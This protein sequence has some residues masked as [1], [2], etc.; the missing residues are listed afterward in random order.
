MHIYLSMICVYAFMCIFLSVYLSICSAPKFFFVHLLKDFVPLIKTPILTKILSRLKFFR[1]KENDYLPKNSNIIIPISVNPMS[2]IFQ[3][4]NSLN[5]EKAKFE[6]RFTPS[7]FNE[8]W[9]RKFQFLAKL[10]SFLKKSFLLSKIVYPH[11]LE[12]RYTCAEQ[13]KKCRV[14]FAEM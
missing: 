6:I 13:Q 9:I 4:M 2:L 12:I 14:L 8:I 11:P 7:G 1:S 3:T 10:N 5:Y